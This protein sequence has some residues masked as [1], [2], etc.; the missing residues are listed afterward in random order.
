M[1]NAAALLH[2]LFGAPGTTAT[3]ADELLNRAAATHADLLE[4]ACADPELARPL[5]G[6]LDYLHGP[7]PAA[8]KR[9]LLCH[10]L[11]IEGLH[12][13]A[14]CAAVLRD[15]HDSVAAPPTGS[16]APPNA[17][18]RAALGHVAL[19]FLLR[20]DRRWEGE[21]T[22]CT[23]PLGRIGFPF[24]D[25]TLTLCT[26]DGDFLGL[27]PVSLVVEQDRAYWRLPDACEPP[28]L[29]LSRADCLRLVVDNDASLEQHRLACPHSHL[30][31]RLQHAGA[32]GRSPVRYDPVGFKDFRAHAGL[33]GG[34]IERLLASVHHNSPAV[35]REFRAFVHS[36]RGYEFP[37]STHGVVGSFSDP[38]LPGVVSINV[39]YTPRHEP[40]LDAFCFTWFGH[41]L[42]H[43]KDY[44]I[45]TIL[46]GE[47]GTLLLNPTARTGV[48]PRYGRPLAV[49]TLFQVPYVHLYEWA[50]LIDFW[51]AGFRGL[52]WRMPHDIDS[53]G[54]DFALEIEEAFELIH[55]HAQLTALGEAA[56]GYFEELFSLTQHRWRF[57]RLCGCH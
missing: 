21:H 16:R 24:S 30:R 36:V 46:Y 47:G 37:T 52:P 40:C 7:A 27:Q 43:T 55:E 23:D 11:F 53:V 29:V 48:I 19:A 10:P 28:F 20:G 22:L 25:W 51:E 39:P 13:L 14:P 57:A 5:A 34:L 1:S 12:G 9:R 6:V 54:E 45:D 32:L 26:D 41:E 31:P 56:L 18:A 33:T 38:T 8:A 3:D 44:L 17:A 15:W 50:L 42:A 4:V 49:R 35:Y 2:R